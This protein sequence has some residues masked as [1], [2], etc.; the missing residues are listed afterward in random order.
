M[1]TLTKFFDTSNTLTLVD[2]K[3]NFNSLPNDKILD[4]SKLKAFADDKINVTQKLMFQVR[5]VQNIV[6]KGENFGHHHFFLFPQV[7]PWASFSE[8]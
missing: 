4:C 2:N 6:G 8:P 1:F 3:T 5:R 7:F